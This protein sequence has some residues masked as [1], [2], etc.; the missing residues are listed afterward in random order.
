MSAK[1]EPIEALE[2]IA[3]ALIAKGKGI[4]AADESTNSIAKRFAMIGVESTP[5]NRRDY[6][7]MLFRSHEA[8]AA[9]I[10]GVI[11]FDETIRQRA[12]DGTPLI[13]LIKAEGAIAG[14]KVDKGLVALADSPRE[15]ITEGLD[16]L[17]ARLRDYYDLGARFAK[18]R[19]V[20]KIGDGLPTRMAI[21]A[22]MDALARYAACCQEAGLVPIIE[23]EVLMEGS[24]DIDICAAVSETVLR[25]LY[26]ELAAQKVVLEATLLKPNMVISATDCP[27]R[28]APEQVATATLAC[29]SQTVPAAIG[30]I[31]FLSGGQGDVEATA[32]LNA[33]NKQASHPWALSYSY[34]RALQ[35]ASLQAWRGESKNITAAQQAFT[36]R[37]RMNS[38]A[39]QGLWS[40][41]HESPTV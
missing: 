21:E 11:L 37:A 40:P 9:A 18:W 1:P 17:A 13:D 15:T 33:I 8:F 41:E 7:E 39:A 12:A 19:A 5:E 14:I 6:R 23:P 32:N 20:I 10:S 2:S 28:A 31:V 30:G 36:H 34:G 22:N 29:F 27:R 35:S 38:L 16:G 25:S 4:L 26:A 3:Y 24:H